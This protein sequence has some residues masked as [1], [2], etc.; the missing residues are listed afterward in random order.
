MVIW[1]ECIQKMSLF[2]FNQVLVI[3]EQ[4]INK[5]FY[6]LWV[7]ASKSCSGHLCSLYKYNKC[8]FDATLGPLTIHLL[9][10]GKVVIFINIEEGAL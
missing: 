6:S 1:T 4:S 9:M 2:G 5:M 10:N 8:Q 3:S 7:K